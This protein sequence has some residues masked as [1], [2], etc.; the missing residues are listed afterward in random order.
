MFVVNPA[1]IQLYSQC[2]K[3]FFYGYREVARLPNSLSLPTDIKIVAEVIKDLYIFI[4]RKGHVPTWQSFIRK[5]EGYYKKFYRQGSTVLPE[6]IKHIAK[7]LTIIQKWYREIFPSYIDAAYVNFPIELALSGQVVYEDFIDIITIGQEVR[8]FS[9]TEE[10]KSVK[11]L[12]NNLAIQVGLWGFSKYADKIPKEFVSYSIEQ[13]K[14]IATS[15]YPMS[16]AIHKT[17]TFV[18]QILEGVRANVWYP[19]YGQQCLSCSY[20]ETCSY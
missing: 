18:R 1:R 11:E 16:G 10:T 13:S 7:L 12:Y 19:S 3:K 8:V 6:D 20:G 4:S 2:P 15:F 14:I 17:E 5:T 9:F